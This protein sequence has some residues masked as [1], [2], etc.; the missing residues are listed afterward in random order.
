MKKLI[1]AIITVALFVNTST[2][3]V[4]PRSWRRPDSALRP[5]AQALFGRKPASTGRGELAEVVRDLS[6]VTREAIMPVED[7]RKAQGYLDRLLASPV[8]SHVSEPF[9]TEAQ[10]LNSE[11]TELLSDDTLFPNLVSTQ[12]KEAVHVPHSTIFRKLKEAVISLFTLTTIA[13]IA[14]YYYDAYL[15][16][17]KTHLAVST[18]ILT[19]ITYSIGDYLRQRIEIL[20][21]AREKMSLEHLIRWTLLSMGLFGFMFGYLWHDLCLLD[22]DA[23]KWTKIG[24]D[25]LVLTPLFFLPCGTTLINWLV[26][27][28][29]FTQAVKDAVIKWS[30]TYFFVLCLWPWALPLCYFVF[31]EKAPVLPIGIISILWATIWSFTMS[32]P[33]GQAS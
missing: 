32:R 11:T 9:L 7:L 23:Q 27:K 4:S 33:E 21:G 12:A 15:E 3:G 26:E 16:F 28:M 22:N 31:A 18:M 25:Q 30:R 29:P 13:F 6:K 2:A 24:L 1:A 14:W 19:G 5:I 20:T 17:R 10:E 8:R